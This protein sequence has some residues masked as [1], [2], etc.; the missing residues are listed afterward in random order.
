MATS[1]STSTAGS[2][3]GPPRAAAPWRQAFL[4]HLDQMGSPEFVLSTLHAA[5]PS[6]A[7]DGGRRGGEGE[8]EGA[9]TA[10]GLSG[11]TTITTAATTGAA[12]AVRWVPRARYCIFRGLWASLPA[13]PH[14]EAPR[15]PPV[16]ESDLPS[17]TTDVRMNKA[18]ELFAS[19]GGGT[20]G[21]HVES[22]SDEPRGS[23]GGGP[24]EA[25]WWCKE[26]ATQWR[27]KGTA[28]VIAPDIEEGQ[29]GGG[30]EPAGVRTV[31]HE[32]GRRMRA[33]DPSK[34]AEWSWA[35]EVTGH[36]GNLSPMMRG[37]SPVFR[38]PAPFALGPPSGLRDLDR[39]GC[40]GPI[41]LGLDSSPGVQHARPGCH[42]I[43]PERV[44]MQ[45]KLTRAYI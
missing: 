6:G 35:R 40:R 42:W 25:V 12:T 10:G 8:G 44:A 2:A 4:D 15:N 16:Y 20:G 19:G 9:G 43:R 33:L 31:R 27:V 14:N 32:L 29:D 18:G 41:E 45:V 28:Y 21:R 34:E 1:T 22:A 36:F 39:Q 24:V 11:A 7:I 26:A 17:F 30:E 38:R 3:V 13:N 37:K 5:P 23:G